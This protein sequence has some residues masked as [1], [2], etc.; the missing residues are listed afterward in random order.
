MQKGIGE[1]VGGEEGIIPTVP[2]GPDTWSLAAGC[3]VKRRVV[4]PQ[5]IFSSLIKL[6]T[7][8]KESAQCP[9]LKNEKMK[10]FVNHI[11]FH[12]R[13]QDPLHMKKDQK[14]SYM[15]ERGGDLWF[16]FVSLGLQRKSW[17]CRYRKSDTAGRLD[18]TN[19][20]ITYHVTQACKSLY[21]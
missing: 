11:H 20:F 15:R 2:D 4:I 18:C 17:R 8:C 7:K 13:C 3:Y 19:I 12:S 5:H 1:S 16:F 10:E 14:Q 9:H 21:L 6:R